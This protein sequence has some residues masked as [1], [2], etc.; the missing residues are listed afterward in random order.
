MSLGPTKPT[1]AKRIKTLLR[2]FLPPRMQLLFKIAF[3]IPVTIPWAREQM[4][5][6]VSPE[7]QYPRVLGNEI[8]SVT[9]IL[10]SG[11]WNM[12]Y[13][14]RL[15][16]HD[17]ENAFAEAIGV[18]HAVAVNTGGV[19]I[20]MTLRALG[21]KPGHEVLHQIDTCVANP[22]AILAAGVTPVF[23]DI[24]EKTLMLSE[25]Q[26]RRSISDST[27]VIMP[28]HMW[29]N[30]ENMDM[31]H[32]IAKEKKLLVLEDCCLS[33]GARYK[34]KNVGSMGDAAVFS[35]GMM[36]PIQGGE[37]GMIVTSD[38]GL[39]KELRALRAW[40]DR[41]GEFGVRDCTVPAW[42]GRMS[43]I[44]AAVVFEQ[45]KKY[46]QMLSLLQENVA[47]FKSAIRDLEGVELWRSD[48]D[49]K[50][51]SY[52]QIV[53]KLTR[54]DFQKRQTEIMAQLK[55]KGVSTWHVNF[56]PINSHSFF[57]KDLWKEWI[58]RGDLA[59]IQQN[60]TGSYPVS[61]KL[62]ASGGFGIF[63]NHFLSRR[64]VDLVIKALREVIF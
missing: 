10:T 14:A 51:A 44:V 2:R 53:L 62:F 28:I 3:G 60:Y 32:K 20:Q 37:G 5:E 52:T 58:L 64:K 29:G 17:F 1:I 16:H 30:P 31:V 47:Y 50:D 61:E 46:P 34:G 11:S 63:R 33:L 55:E 42:N 27:K 12:H 22:F 39:A 4:P 6:A 21:L 56:E 43:E 8:E 45:L 38:A 57:K 24:D 35:F 40:G 36:K 26:V 54:E 25:E 9:Q 59:R 13:G 7:G 49:V 19:A 48:L 23:S 18:E 15:V 41:Q